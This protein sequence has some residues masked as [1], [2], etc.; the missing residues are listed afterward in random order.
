MFYGERR[1]GTMTKAMAIAAA[2]ITVLFLHSPMTQQYLGRQGQPQFLCFTL[3][4]SFL[5]PEIQVLNVP[6][7]TMSVAEALLRTL[8]PFP[9]LLIA[10]AKR[11]SSATLNLLRYLFSLWNASARKW[12]R[13]HSLEDDADPS[14]L[15]GIGA[16]AG[17]S[18]ESATTLCS[19]DEGSASSRRLLP[20][21]T[22]TV[23][24]FL[25]KSC[26]FMT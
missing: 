22:E 2:F 12:K 9:K 10:I 3:F 18:V 16:E 11:C 7:P 25:D 6:I 1:N 26:I 24:S 20:Y 19:K 13:E 17:A 21:G 8:V 5:W 4:V 15:P 14:R 23:S